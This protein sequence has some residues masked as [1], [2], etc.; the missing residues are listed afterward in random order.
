MKTLLKILGGLVLLVLLVIGGAL[1]YVN[2]ALPKVSAPEDL[3]VD[4]SPESVARGD[5]LVHHVAVCFVCHSET[6][7]NLYT[8]PIIP[9][10]AGHG[11]DVFSKEDGFPGDFY[12]DNLTP[13][14][15]GDWTD[16]EILR[17]L[18]A[19]VNKAGDPLF[20]IMPYGNYGTLDRRDLED[21]I[22]YLR[23]LPAGGEQQPESAP[24]F[25]MG[26]IMKTMPSDAPFGQ[27]PDPSDRVAYGE[28]LTRV[29]SCNVCHTPTDD[30][31]RPIMELAFS[32]GEPFPMKTG[33]FAISSNITP[34]QDGIGSWNETAFLSAFRAYADS[35]YTPTPVGE[36]QANT[37]MPW[38]HYAGMTDED[39]KAIYAY[40][41]TLDPVPG[42]H[43]KFVLE[44][45]ER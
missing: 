25:P 37:M 35:V 26:I 42:V 22:A 31:H 7:P 12:A 44:L 28:Y 9:G 8:N 40:L 30:K 21:M 45:P 15:L 38:Q 3:T 19:G 27:R 13:V 1:I 43:E 5:Y 36:N 29:A 11:G 23:S 34:H 2:A 10:T 39:L 33:G 17:A 14:H 18:T 32:G 41:H 6:N 16:G 20:P 4:R 24:A